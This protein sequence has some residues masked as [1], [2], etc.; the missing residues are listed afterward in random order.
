MGKPWG[1]GYRYFECE[2]GAS[3]SSKTRDYISYSIEPCPICFEVS[4]PVKNE[5]ISEFKLDE[6]ENLK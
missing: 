3:W 4:S 5:S 1:P 2:C 6:N